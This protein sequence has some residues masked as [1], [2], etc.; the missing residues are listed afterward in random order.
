MF[1]MGAIKGAGDVAINSIL[2]ARV[3][4]PFKDL[5]ILFHELMEV[6]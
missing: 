2:N 6:K 4:G 3:D 1:G 5:E